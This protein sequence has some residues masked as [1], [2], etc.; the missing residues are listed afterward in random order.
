MN[1]YTVFIFYLTNIFFDSI[2]V[3][4]P[5]TADGQYSNHG[6]SNF[7]MALDPWD[8]KCPKIVKTM[9]VFVKPKGLTI[10]FIQTFLYDKENKKGFF[11]MRKQL[12]LY[13]TH[14]SPP[15]YMHLIH[16]I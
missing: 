5:L 7:F 14:D 10:I 11:I 8:K 15:V 3:V 9:A 1:A 16:L 12:N 6:F 2:Q 4:N 13:E